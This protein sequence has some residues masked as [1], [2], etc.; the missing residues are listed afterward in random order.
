MRKGFLA[1]YKGE[2]YH[3]GEFRPS[4]VLHRLEER[5]NYLHS[6]LHSVIERTFEVWKNKWKILRHMPRFHIRTQSL[7][8]VATMVLH[9]FVRAHEIN[10]DVECSRSTGGTSFG[11]ERG[12]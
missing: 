2:R 1:P 3:I 10:N 12:H 7:I 8:I 11:S 9:N 4:E 5:F 6:S